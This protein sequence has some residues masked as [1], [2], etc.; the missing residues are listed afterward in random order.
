MIS[1]K[2]RFERIKLFFFFFTFNV[3]SFFRFILVIKEQN[4]I[5]E[6]VQTKD[7]HLDRWIPLA[8]EIY[9]DDDVLVNV[10]MMLQK[11]E[12]S[13]QELVDVVQH[14]FP[15]KKNHSFK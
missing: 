9:L 7:I 12:L 4:Q 8:Y 13:S 2:K 10:L 3:S 15:F 5:I 1:I 6:L 11:H 14:S